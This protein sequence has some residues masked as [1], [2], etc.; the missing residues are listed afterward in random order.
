[1]E[2]SAISNANGR[3]AT[4]FVGEW[5]FGVGLKQS[6]RGLDTDTDTGFRLDSLSVAVADEVTL[7]E[8]LLCDLALRVRHDDIALPMVGMSNVAGR[9]AAS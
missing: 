2:Q 8:E 4:T 3:S 6:L 9:S 1:M 5:S 7:G